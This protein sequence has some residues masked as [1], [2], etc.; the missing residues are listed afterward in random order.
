M[1][2]QTTPVLRD[3]SA[4]YHVAFVF[5][6]AQAVASDRQVVYVNGVRITSYSVTTYTNAPSHVGGLW[7]HTSGAVY[8]GAVWSHFDGYLSEINFIDGQALTPN[9]F[10]ETNA[11]GVWVPK[12]YTGTY[13]TNGFY[14]PFNDGTSTTTLGYDRSGNGNNW[15]ATNVSLTDGAT[16]DWMVDTP[17]N[18]F[19]VF[20]ALSPGIGVGYSTLS[21]AN[22]TATSTAGGSF[23]EGAYGSVQVSSG[24]WYVEITPTS[25]IP[26]ASAMIG[27]AST[28]T[29]YWYYSADGNK[30][31]ASSTSS[32]YGDSYINTDVIGIALD[33]DAGTLAFYKNGVSQ[34][35][36]FTGLS[37]EWA[38]GVCDASGGGTTLVA[39]A[40][41]G[42]RPFKYT[43]PTGFKSLC[44]ANLPAATITDPSQHH[45]VIT[46]TKSGDT[47]FTL[48]WNATDYDT[49][50]W[51]KRRDAAGDW[52]QIDGLRGYDK[53]LK[54][55]STA[56]ETTDANVLGVSGTTCTLRSTLPNGT[57]VIYA[58]K[59][60]LVSA[61][62]TNTAG[63]ITSTVSA[64]VTA[65]LSIVTYTGTGANATVGHGLGDVPEMVIV[66]SRGPT[67]R[68]WGVY[69]V[70]VGNTGALYLDMTAA[71]NTASFHWN[72]TSPTSTVFSLGNGSVANSAE[73]VVAYVHAEIPG[74]SK[75]GSYTGN[76]AADGP[77]VWGDM[78]VMDVLIKR[79]NAAGDN[80]VLIDAARN[81]GNVANNLVLPSSDSAELASSTTNP[82]DFT[83]NGIKLRG[84]GT[85]SNVSGGTYIYAAYAKS[86][87][88]AENTAPATTR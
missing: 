23:P 4:W 29:S 56:A 25:G 6:P 8:N 32:A 37:G 26:L 67:A 30:W 73:S 38:F 18:N 54:S 51:I 24:K 88:G 7:L 3:P 9:S 85:S 15:T 72:N 61:R 50:F 19:A 82:V 65:G 77:F 33:L 42:Q 63:S 2:V 46:V 53:I 57:Y 78:S 87:F 62:A 39:H 69:H 45:T 74:Y 60:G 22:L 70:S 59:A 48:P 40:N 79:V 76:G 66:K 75:F 1:D 14:L 36:A 13:G 80:W 81:P 31:V 55:N 47:N 35:T 43:P 41:F 68:S 64:N 27:V 21:N 58:W 12:K 16:Y 71:T 17:T 49:L 34:G 20:N 44:T 84:T 83:A 5:D 11:D 28:S 86:P 10:G 52:Y